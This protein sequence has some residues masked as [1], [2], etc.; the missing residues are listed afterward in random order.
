LQIVLQV[1]QERASLLLGV[2]LVKRAMP[3]STGIRIPDPLLQVA[4]CLIVS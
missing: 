2:G 1:Q 3:S 4:N